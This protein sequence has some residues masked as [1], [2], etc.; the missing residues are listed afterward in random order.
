MGVE[1][2]PERQQQK[3]S[4]TTR[5]LK[6][7]IV[8]GTVGLLGTSSISGLVMVCRVLGNVGN[9]TSVLV[10]QGG[11]TVSIVDFLCDIA[12]GRDILQ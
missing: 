10:S 6:P 2:C 4:T 12:W 1:R 9:D 5:L 3:A 7:S 8:M 11:L